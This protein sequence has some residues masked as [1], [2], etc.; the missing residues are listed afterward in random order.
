MRTATADRVVRLDDVNRRL[1][2]AIR[3]L[4]IAVSELRRLGATEAAA[5][6]EAA[7]KEAAGPF[8]RDGRGDLRRAPR[9]RRLKMV[10]EEWRESQAGE[11][12]PVQTSAL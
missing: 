8:N 9:V 3:A 1:R 12:S 2:R 6:V 5:P 7:R 4:A 11:F 10:W